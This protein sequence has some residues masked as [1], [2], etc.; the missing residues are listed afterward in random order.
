M[1]PLRVAVLGAGGHAKVVVAALRASGADVVG[2]YVRNVGETGAHV[3]GA[4]VLHEDELPGDAVRFLA[5]GDNALRKRLAAKV[6]GPWAT[7]VH[8]S[9]VVDPSVV[10]G[11]GALVCAGVVLQPD[12]RVGAH[13]IVNTSAHVD[14]D[15]R[16]GAF[17]HVAPG[18]HL[19]GDVI[20]EEGA[21]VGI[22]A[23]IIPGKRVGA[24]ATVGA[25]AVVVRDVEASETVVGVPARPSRN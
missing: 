20:V 19:A 18:C 9:A 24:W 22:G 8:P 4:P 17:A 14:H 23:S 1:N 15:G 7:V 12:V 25:G 5:T 13:A 3:L 6:G 11:E 21:F 2:C 10:L 16:I